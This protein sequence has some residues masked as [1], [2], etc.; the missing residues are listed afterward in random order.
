LNELIIQADALRLPLRDKSVDLVI[1]SPPYSDARTYSIGADRKVETW[2]A[3]MKTITIEAMRVSCGLVMWVCAG[4]GNYDL[5]PE[6]LMVE[7]AQLKSVKV[8]RPCIWTK[9]A[10]PTGSNWFSNDWEYIVA[11]GRRGHKHYWAPENIATPMKYSS[12]GDFRQRRK[13]G[14]RQKGG[15][16]PSH[17]FR[18]RPSNVFHVTVG[19]N[20]MGSSLAHQNE[21]PYPEKLIDPFIRCLCPPTGTILDPFSGSGTTSAVARRFDRKCIAIDIRESQCKLTKERIRS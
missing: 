10:P 17:S 2:V 3:W 19:G 7:M 13:D 21:A 9:N 16:Y 1:G 5:A 12:G 18:K 14:T 15:K 20:H 4:R 6:R 8:F 11:F